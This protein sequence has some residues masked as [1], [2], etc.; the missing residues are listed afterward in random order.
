MLPYATHSVDM[1]KI[2]KY[3]KYLKY[4]KNILKK[5]L[6]FKFKMFFYNW[7]NLVLQK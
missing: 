7:I 6:I 4:V 3:F 1:L 5:F 2:V